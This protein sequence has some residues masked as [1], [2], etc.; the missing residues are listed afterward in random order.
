M[1]LK[2]IGKIRKTG[3]SYVATIPMQYVSNNLLDE[4]KEYQFEIKEV[5]DHV[6]E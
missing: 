5:E 2:F 1:K 3:N 6:E 4:N